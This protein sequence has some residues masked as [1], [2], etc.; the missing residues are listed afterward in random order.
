MGY[1]Q[2]KRLRADKLTRFD[3][4]TLERVLNFFNREGLDVGPSDLFVK[5]KTLET[6]CDDNSTCSQSALAT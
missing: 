2:V 1:R 6:K 5:V 3:L 4:L